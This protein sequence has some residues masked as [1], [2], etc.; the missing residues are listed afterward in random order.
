VKEKNPERAAARQGQGA[1]TLRKEEGFRHLLRDALRIS[2]APRIRRFHY[3]HTDLHAGSGWNEEASCP[4]SPVVFLE[5]ARLRGRLYR[6]HFCDRNLPSRLALEER[7]NGWS[8]PAGS[9]FAVWGLDNSEILPHVSR[10]IRMKEPNPERA[11]GTVLCDPNGWR[12]VPYPELVTF[13]TAF[14]SIDLI[15]NLNVNLF[16]SAGELRRRSAPGFEDWPTPAEIITPLDRQH[17]LIRNIARHGGH[18]F[19]ILL[20]RNLRQKVG[21]FRDFYPISS[22]VGRDILANLRRVPVEQ[23]TLFPEITP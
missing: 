22:P 2:N 6:A 17:W 5:E 21:Q 15:I 18:C 11:V 1:G 14:P 19:T 3:W 16:R 9:T 20:G 12:D 13:A 4:G 8:E 23:S 7:L 10:E